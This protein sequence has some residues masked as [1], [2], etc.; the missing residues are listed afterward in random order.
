MRFEVLGTFSISSGSRSVPLHGRMRRTLLGVLLVRANTYVPVNVL[1]EALWESRWEPRAVPKLHWHVHKLRQA[2]PEGDRLGFDNG[3]YRLEVHPGEL[4]VE[5]FETL[6]SQ[7]LK[8]ADPAQRASLIRQALTHWH[9]APY[10]GLDVPLLSD[11]TMRLS[12]HRLVLLEELYQ[13]ELDLGR[14]ASAAVELTE[15][16]R[17]HPLRQRAQYLLMDA[18][19]RAGRTSDALAAYRRARRFSVDQL[20]LEP[21]PELRVLERRILAGEV[22]GAGAHRAPALLHRTR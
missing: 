2:L 6:G 4:D 16:V 22:A 1:T 19:W 12:E 17:R 10:D 3:G 11:E 20:G 7:A 15:L 8:S 5:T 14:H 18:L 9:G 21:G 13:A